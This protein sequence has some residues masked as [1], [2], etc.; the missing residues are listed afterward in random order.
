[1]MLAM[2]LAAVAL[3]LEYLRPRRSIRGLYRFLAGRL[4]AAAFGIGAGVA[5][6]IDG[7][8]FFG[9]PLA[10]YWA[11]VSVRRASDFISFDVEVRS[12]TQN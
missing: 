3:L 6:M 7:W 4:L 5:L 2:L 8:W 1:M 12:S 9:A 11:R 10:V